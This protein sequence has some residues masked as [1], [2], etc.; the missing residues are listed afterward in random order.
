M[1]RLGELR[2]RTWRELEALLWKLATTDPVCRGIQTRIFDP[3]F[4]TKQVAKVPARPGYG[5]A[6]CAKTSWTNRTDIQ[7]RRHTI[8]RTDSDQAAQ[9]A[10][11][12]ENLHE[13][14]K[15]GA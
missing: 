2:I 12:A 1:K 6:H 13:A 9:I 5:D 15:E 4:T 10:T 8:H 11:S 3:F 7:A 14:T